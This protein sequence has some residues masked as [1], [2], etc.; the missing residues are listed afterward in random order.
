MVHSHDGGRTWTIQN[1]TLNDTPGQ[2]PGLN[3]VIALHFLP[4]GKNGWAAGRWLTMQVTADGGKSWTF[5]SK[6][7]SKTPWMLDY[8][9][10]FT[11]ETEP[12]ART[13]QLTGRVHPPYWAASTVSQLSDTQTYSLDA[14]Y[15]PGHSEGIEPAKPL[16]PMLGDVQP[17]AGDRGISVVAPAIFAS[18]DS[19][20]TFNGS[21]CSN[22]LAPASHCAETSPPFQPNAIWFKDKS[23]GFIAGDRG[24]IAQTTNA[25]HNCTSQASRVQQDLRSLYFG[26][27][28]QHGWA[29]GSS[30][31]IIHTNDGGRTWVRQTSDS[32]ES[33]AQLMWPPL[34]FW[35]G[36]MV[37]GLVFLSGFRAEVTLPNIGPETINNDAPIDAI[38]Q[39]RLNFKP[40]VEGLSK[41]LINRNT[42][43]PVAIAITANWGRG[44]S[45]LMSLLRHDLE[46]KGYR[47]VWFNAWH[48][49][50]EESLLAFF[51]QKLREDIMP[52]WW[53]RDDIRVR[54]ALLSIR[55]A[56]NLV[57]TL[58]LVPLVCL[59]LAYLMADPGRH[60]PAWNSVVAAISKIRGEKSEAETPGSRERSGKI[61]A[62]TKTGEI[63]PSEENESG[64]IIASTSTLGTL[65]VA[66]MA[67]YRGMRAFD[68]RPAQL[69][70]KAAGAARL[71]DLEAQTSLRY[72]FAREFKDITEAI[73]PERVI[74][75]VQP[76]KPA[77]KESLCR[78]KMIMSYLGKVDMSY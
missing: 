3:D 71:K 61:L 59:S 19:W 62:D 72:R 74:V 65:L 40:I 66:F 44:K 17:T 29:V 48:H 52:R 57:P 63:R 42:E 22:T 7:A 73:D 30:G 75:T 5:N 28:A 26:I 68:V 16:E 53:T 4:D 33:H 14:L 69:L 8:S 58:L 27:D 55:G 37:V 70:S 13:S 11:G 32:P 21:L 36:L 51:L 38:T 34:W 15:S 2:Y 67:L 41:F 56:R 47:P 60:I 76:L 78:R 64:S 12:R 20:W 10:S 46:R 45:S 23:L 54:A 24:N 39:D 43:P 6:Y 50:K 77:I 25:G 9:L 49:Q 31:T 18:L 35:P 1:M